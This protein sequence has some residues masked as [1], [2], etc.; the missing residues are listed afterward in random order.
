MKGRQQ[1]QFYR[2]HYPGAGRPDLIVGD[3]TLKVI[4]CSESGLRYEAPTT[5]AAPQVG[6]HVRGVVRFGTRSE[7]EVEGVVVRVTGEDVAVSLGERRIPFATVLK[8]QRYLRSHYI[9]HLARGD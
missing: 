8:E 1:R 2:V 9:S 7:A 6:D 5:G 4:E 3:Q